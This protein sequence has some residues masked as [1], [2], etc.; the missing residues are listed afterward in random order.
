MRSD[1]AKA[2][3]KNH[4]ILIRMQQAPFSK[5]TPI[6]IPSQPDDF[7]DNFIE[8]EVESDSVEGDDAALNLEQ[9]QEGF[10]RDMDLLRS[11]LAEL[12]RKVGEL[13]TCLDKVEDEKFE[14]KRQSND[15][16]REL[17]GKLLVSNL[18]AHTSNKKKRSLFS[19]KE[20]SLNS[21]ELKVAADLNFV[22]RSIA[23]RGEAND[24][25]KLDIRFLNTKF[26][27]LS[28]CNKET[29]G[30]LGNLLLEKATL[31]DNVRC[32]VQLIVDQEI[33][34]R[35]LKSKLRDKF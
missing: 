6:P 2:K 27:E 17:G 25:L 22:R 8:D 16:Q 26:D 35:Q 31:S 5:E 21:D 1:E 12:R 9:Q 20:N 33:L 14:L 23:M 19:S 4:H 30:K 7:F 3:K 34:I 10:R 29:E 13:T 28:L 32:Q 18:Q 24:K 11:E 15:V